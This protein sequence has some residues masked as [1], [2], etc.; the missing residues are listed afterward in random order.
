MISFASSNIAQLKC[1]VINSFD[2]INQKHIMHGDKS[3][4]L[5]G[6]QQTDLFPKQRS[7]TISC[8]HKDTFCSN[9][10]S[11]TS[12]K[13]YLLFCYTVVKVYNQVKDFVQHCKQKMSTL[14][15]VPSSF[16]FE[17]CWTSR[18]DTKSHK[19]PG[20]LHWHTN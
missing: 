18:F 19:L 5:A 8:K 4:E 10:Y 12:M 3:E 9:I 13:M 6:L 15:I 1:L 20:K 14:Q 11:T 16:Q 7:N 2:S 17:H